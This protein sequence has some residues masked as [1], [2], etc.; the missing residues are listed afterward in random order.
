MKDKDVIEAQ[1]ARVLGFFPRVDA[2][3]SGLF[4]INSAILT[5]SALNVK[6]GDF[7]R[8]YIA[9]PA[10][11]LL[12]CLGASL[13][14]LYRCNFPE[15]KGGGG[16]L[17]YFGSVQRRTEVEYKADLEAASDDAYRSDMIEQVWRNSVILCTKYR[18]V[19]LAIRL[20]LAALLPFVVFLT[21][22]SI[23]HSSLPNLKG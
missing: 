13:A 20:T 7:R 3:V 1:L 19:A 16:S 4:T 22:T 18:E 2:K 9:V 12:L 5:I 10:V 11:A 23:E 14:F 17:I 6:A 21:M 15:L 8:W